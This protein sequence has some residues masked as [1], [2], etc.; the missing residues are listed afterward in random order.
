MMRLAIAV[1][2]MM[3]A[4][5]RP[6]VLC[7]DYEVANYPPIPKD[8]GRHSVNA[9]ES[10]R[11]PQKVIGWNA[12]GLLLESG[13]VLALSFGKALP[14][15]SWLLTW[16][17]EHGVE[18]RHGCVVTLVPIWHLCDQS[19]YGPH[20][21]RVNLVEALI[22]LGGDESTMGHWGWQQ[23]EFDKFIA[24]QRKRLDTSVR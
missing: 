22:F 13:G 4:C 3:C 10:L 20:L 23:R 18:A 2:A 5:S 1:C 16:A 9:I 19:V 7:P 14:K 17:V 24:W 6:S 11:D 21:A 15:K 12:K 8:A